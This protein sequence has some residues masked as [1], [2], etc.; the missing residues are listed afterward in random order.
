[1]TEPTEDVRLSLDLGPDLTARLRAR[2]AVDRRTVDAVV[3]DAVEEYLANHPNHEQVRAAGLAAM[4]E[5][6]AEHGPFTEEEI[7]AADAW[8]DRLMRPADDEQDG[9]LAGDPQDGSDV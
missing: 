4:A 7:A 2:A 9:P 3:A 8:I 6:E 5:Y 1:M